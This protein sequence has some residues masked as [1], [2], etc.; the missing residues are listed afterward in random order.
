[1]TGFSEKNGVLHA[2][3]LPLDDMAKTY[4][5]PC[6][7]YCAS[8]IRD[9][10]TRLRDALAGTL[11]KP[12]L[13]TFATKA[14]SNLAV[15]HLMSGMGLGA[16]IVS[17]GEMQR[18]LLAGM[19][20]DKIVFS[21]VSKSKGEITSALKHKILQINVE[22]R[23]ELERIAAIAKEMDVIA[24]VSFR[25]N[26]DVDALT[27]AKITTGKNEN[28]FGLSQNEA[29]TLY[30]IAASHPN[31]RPRGFSVHIGSQLTDLTP[32]RQAYKKLADL[33]SKMMD[34]GLPVESL[35]LGGG[36][37]ITYRN[38][39]P[40]DLDSYA[41]IIKEI[42]EPL[43]TELVLEPGRYLTG[44]AGIL[45]T[46]VSY[47]KESEGRKFLIIDAGMNDLL[48]PALY[49]AWHDIRPI[50]VREGRPTYHYDIVGPICETG[51]TFAFQ[52]EMPEL[53]AGDLVAIMTAGAYGFV[54]ASNYNT[55]PRPPEVLV[56]GT[57]HALI[58]Q[59][60]GFDDMI[61]GE[62]IPDWLDKSE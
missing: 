10:V 18:A 57:R 32:Y 40:P 37:G 43:G 15:L 13:I 7:I 9:S 22:S 53:K 8:T 11:S 47:I 2:D 29:E 62:L 45:L 12:P 50:D 38:E 33:A 28:K 56:E 30:R 54:M 5:T 1:M 49:D 26:P 4:G 60:E 27:H 34:K 31:L 39:T 51:D 19:A 42:V 21:G 24:P 59:R 14:N 35:D 58:R 25:Y 36:L 3:S 20:P 41:R 55:R 16:D 46:E 6:Y 52:R 23:P 48:R 61:K 17:G 44:E